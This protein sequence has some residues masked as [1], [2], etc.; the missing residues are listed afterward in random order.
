MKRPDKSKVQKASR[1][2]EE[3][4]ETVITLKVSEAASALKRV[5]LE[6]LQRDL[7]EI[8]SLLA[9]LKLQVAES[10]VDRRQ[11]WQLAD[12][13][14]QKLAKYLFTLLKALLFCNHL[15]FGELVDTSCV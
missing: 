2:L 15:R 1:L 10:P 5:V 14:L 12:K 7:Q 6:K 13:L 11:A 4:V 9:E 8:R 3:A